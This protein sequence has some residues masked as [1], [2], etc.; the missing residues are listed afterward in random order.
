MTAERHHLAATERTLSGSR[1]PMSPTKY[2]LPSYVR[3]TFGG[4]DQRGT[5]GG[6]EQRDTFGGAEQRDTLACD[7]PPGGA[8]GSVALRGYPL[9][10]PVVRPDMMFLWKIRKKMIVGIA[11]MTAAAT[12]TFVGVP[13]EKA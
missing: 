8:S 4:A 2:L 10:L 3:V 1:V 5:F 11:A 6:A 12:T 7:H 13:P 9:R